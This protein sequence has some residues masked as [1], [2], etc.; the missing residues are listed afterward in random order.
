M[1]INMRRN[2][3][4]GYI[5]LSYFA[6]AVVAA[7]LLPAAAGCGRSKTFRAATGA[8]WGTTY[9][10]TYNASRDLSDSIVAE[11]R[12]VE[13]ALSPFDSM[14]VISKINRGE[15]VEA[16]PM[17]STVFL[18][19]RRVNALSGGAFDPT[20]APLINLWG[21]GYRNY[22][23]E[24]SQEQIDSALNSVGIRECRIKDGHII[25]KNRSTE[26]NFSAIT[27]GFGVD[28]VAEV[29]RRNGCTDYMVEI[30][31]EVSLSGSNP[32]GRP[33]RIQVDAPVS[34]NTG[35]SHDR[36]MVLSLSGCGVATSGNYRNFKDGPSG[37]FGHTISAKTGRPVATQTLSATVVATSV[38]LAD[39]LATACMAMPE[40]KAM[41]M[42]ES[43]EDA[44][45][46]LVIDAGNGGWTVRK[47]SGFGK[48]ET[49]Q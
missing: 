31:G 3:F 37:R 17:V 34:D 28:R 27:K 23:G 40:D 7:V 35:L 10:I 32:K 19:S 16:G 1:I 4:R 30:G 36:L 47:T 29:L 49:L 6:M 48:Y 46:L 9:H 44:E 22:S 38:M 15:D 43:I 24:P 14:S 45:A 41:A 20:V 13:L 42:I 25:K 18:E 12:R 2:L 21:F 39:A 33:W 11:M 5:P 26:F 8:V